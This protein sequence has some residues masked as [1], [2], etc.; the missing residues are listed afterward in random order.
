VALL[1]VADT[2]STVFLVVYL[3]NSLII[4]FGILEQLYLSTLELTFAIVVFSTVS[5]VATSIAIKYVPEF[6]EF[7]KFEVAVIFWLATAAVGDIV[8]TV[9]LVRYLRTHRTGYAAT[10]DRIDRI[11]RLTV[12]TGMLSSIW[13]IIDLA[14][15]LG[16]PTGTHLI[17]N[18][19]LSKLYSNS[20]M[21]SLNSRGGWL[22]EG[23]R[24]RTTTSIISTQIN[25]LTTPAVR[26]LGIFLS[27]YPVIDL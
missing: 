3:Y 16:D 25:V 13:A 10:D 19:P 27:S 6:E 12:Q 20:L 21:S 2:I 22:S 15:Y 17:F 5:G 23:S 8:I 14:V 9:G 11:I 1:F 7:Q 26:P 18:F 4:H 24:G